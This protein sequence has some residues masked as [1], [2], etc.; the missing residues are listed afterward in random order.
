MLCR[1]GIRP[2]RH[3]GMRPC[4]SLQPWLLLRERSLF[5]RKGLSTVAPAAMAMTNMRRESRSLLD[6]ETTSSSNETTTT[7]QDVTGLQR[8]QM[9][10]I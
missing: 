6:H 7:P 3:R 8:G 10:L 1:S 4:Y 9:A 5:S 2:E